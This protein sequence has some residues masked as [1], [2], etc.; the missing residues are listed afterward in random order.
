MQLRQLR[1]FCVF[2]LELL[3][4]AFRIQY[5]LAAGKKGM[6]FR[7]DV[8]LYSVHGRAGLEA[9]SACAGHLGLF[10]IWMY[11]LFQLRASSQ[12]I[13]TYIILN[14]KS[15][16]QDSEG[17]PVKTFLTFSIFASTSL[18][19]TMPK[20]APPSTSAGKWDVPS[21]LASASRTANK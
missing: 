19:A 18:A 10:I 12:L 13:S 7:T 9:L 16:Y 14:Y 2:P 17:S 6:A 1:F 5:L 11:L 3:D 4:P 15:T 8:H 21:T 20:M